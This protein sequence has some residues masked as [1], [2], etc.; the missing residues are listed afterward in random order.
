MT[1]L[2]LIGNATLYCGDCLEILPTLK[3]RTQTVLG[4]P[5]DGNP[6]F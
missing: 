6:T 3:A 1:N 4:C 2:T 5:K